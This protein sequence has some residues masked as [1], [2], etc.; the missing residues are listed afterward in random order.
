MLK[1]MARE[2]WRELAALS[3]R[4]LPDLP[5]GMPSVTGGGRHPPVGYRGA[6]IQAIRVDL[7]ERLIRSA[8]EKR[9]A[10]G[11]HPFFVNEAMAISM[12]LSPETIAALMRQAGFRQK[13]TRGLPEGAAGPPA[14]RR[15]LWQP[16]SKIAP[17]RHKPVVV[18]AHTPSPPPVPPKT[19]L[20]SSAGAFAALAGMMLRGK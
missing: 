10:N 1:P 6:G 19:P 3:G 8:H 16:P 12:G 2:L 17:V 11:R 7:A 20:E 13:E 9:V 4:S 5:P 14:P 18:V 15:W